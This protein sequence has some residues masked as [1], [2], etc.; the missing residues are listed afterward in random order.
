MRREGL[1][2]GAPSLMLIVV[3]V[4]AFLHTAQQEL[5]G[6]DLLIPAFVA[7]I[8]VVAVALARQ[9]VSAP[10]LGVTEALMV[11]Y[12]GWV[13]LSVVLPHQYEALVPDTGAYIDLP[14]RIAT[15]VI[16]PLA[17]YVLAK[18][19]LT[20]ERSVRW[21]LWSIV[22]MTAYSAWVSIIAFDGPP[23]LV[24]PRFIVEAPAWPGRA[25]GVFNQ[26][27]VNGLLLVIGIVVCLVLT[28]RPGTPRAQRVGLYVLVAA[29]TY[30]VYLTHTRAAV[31]GLALM[32]V[33]G[34][35]GARGWRHGFVAIGVLGSVGLASQGVST[36]LSSDRAAGGFGS[37]AE[38]VD[39]LNIAAT[40]AR[41]ILN[42]PVLGIGLGRFAMYNT[43]EH[44]AWSPDVD[45]TRGQ[46]YIAHQNEL[47]IAAE[48]G[49][50][51]LAL[52]LGVLVGIAVGLWRAWR[53]LPADGLLGRPL[54]V[55][56]GIA[57]AVM[58]ENGLT[59][60]L[61]VLEFTTMLPLALAGAVAGLAERRRREEPDGPV[62]EI[63][64]AP[65][66]IGS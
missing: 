3:L 12:L 24:W 51:G 36:L 66:A 18:T 33:L 22:G 13:L 55:L 45:W 15:G 16:L 39:R 20:T 53:V 26:P 34:A 28:G 64:T 52:W 56:A 23:S 25:V 7:L 59:V 19:V 11:A 6:P 29:A 8:V 65:A 21:L 54:V 50:V 44:A 37:S 61:R 27:V 38:V 10:V 14:R 30:A 9:A 35:A 17:I 63:E 2:A 42:H 62:S 46:G 43:Y 41:A 5:P 1:L 58:V 48:L 47:G 49:L 4:A 57:L 60:D 31:L 40:C 32:V